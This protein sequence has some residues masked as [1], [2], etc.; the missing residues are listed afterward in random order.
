MTSKL[1]EAIED[2]F[3]G[4]CSIVD[5]DDIVTLQLVLLL[6]MRAELDEFKTSVEIFKKAGVVPNYSC[7]ILECCGST[8]GTFNGHIDYLI[9]E[10]ANVNTVGK[11]GTSCLHQLAW[12][13]NLEY[14]KK[15]IEYDADILYRDHKMNDVYA[16]L[17][18]Y[19]TDNDLNDSDKN[20]DDEE[21]P[22]EA[23][24]DTAEKESM[25]QE[26]ENVRVFI[27]QKEIE[28]IAKLRDIEKKYQ[29][30]T[31]MIDGKGIS[32]EI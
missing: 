16:Y 27:R 30:L 20:S 32:V 17:D 19:L 25:K 6:L 7:L 3:G 22:E 15:F 28:L 31:K 14:L 21:I 1:L 4:L 29:A 8:D 9:S 10:G 24:N 23:V 5:H 11:D 13:G 2:G 12:S 26:V 18:Y